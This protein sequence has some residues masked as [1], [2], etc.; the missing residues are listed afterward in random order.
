MNDKSS[1]KSSVSLESGYSGVSSKT[2]L[3]ED[4]TLILEISENGSKTYYLIPFGAPD[5]LK[6]KKKSTK[7]HICNDH[8]FVAKH[9]FG[10]IFLSIVKK[11]K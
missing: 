9:I 4:S 6:N 1:R 10:Y 11:K 5:K 7:L 8:I 2:Y 3:G